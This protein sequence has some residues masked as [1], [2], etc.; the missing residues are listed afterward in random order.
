MFPSKS[1]QCR[2]SIMVSVGRLGYRPGVARVGAT[3]AA[4]I[5]APRRPRVCIKRSIDRAGLS[6]HGGRSAARARRAQ[7]YLAMSVRGPKADLGRGATGLEG[8]ATHASGLFGFNSKILRINQAHWSGADKCQR[9]DHPYRGLERTYS[10]V[11]SPLA[12]AMSALTQMLLKKSKIE[13][14]RKSRE[15]RLLVVS[16]AARLCRTDTRVYDHFCGN[17][18]GPSHCRARDAPAAL[19]NFVRHPEKTFSTVSPNE[20]TSSARATTSEKCQTH[21]SQQFVAILVVNPLAL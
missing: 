21:A 17:R 14:L 9:F 19:K 5:A 4:S 3:S 10:R 2:Q 1:S 13:R 20:L 7:N 8:D 6:N 12:T 16:A 18:C 15:S 11:K